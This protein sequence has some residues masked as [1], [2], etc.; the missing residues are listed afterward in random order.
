MPH[1]FL[2][3]LSFLQTDQLWPLIIL[4]GFL[5]F[6]SLVPLPPNDFWWHLKI[7][8]LIYNGKSIPTTNLFAWTLSPDA[9]FTYGAWLGELLM[10]LFYKIGRLELVTFMRTL[11]A[12]ITFWLVAY[13]SWR[14]SGSW[15]LSA[16]A[17]ALAC[18]MTINNLPTRPQIWSWVPF[19]IYLILLGKYVDRQIHPRWLLALPALMIFWVNAH[20]AFILGGVLIGI[21][22][23]GEVLRKLIFPKDS[24]NWKEIAY[25]GGSGV[26]TGLTMFINPRHIGIIRYVINLMTDQP[27]QKLI[28]EWQSP[29]PVGIANTIF[30]LSI[31]ILIVGLIFTKNRLTITEALLILCFLWLAWSGQRYVVWYGLVCTPIITKVIRGLPLSL[32]QLTPQKNFLNLIITIILFIPVL[33]VQPWFVERFPLPERYWKLVIRHS[34][35]GPLVGVET[36]VEA[37]EYL[38]EHPG[39]KLFNEMGYGSYLIWAL[40]D[41]SVFIDP[42]VE[43]YPFDQWEDY[44]HITNGLRYNE[45]LDKYGADRLL[46]DT[47]LQPELAQVLENDPA[48]TEEYQ[49]SRSQIWSKT[50]P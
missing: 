37:V 47:Q 31:L 13:E 38:R 23:V 7:G 28:V 35:V 12:G 11:L 42:R 41:Q 25:L 32:P 43:L 14:K 2:K 48:W 27:S 44:V 46:I 20:G 45:L 4:A 6:V 18:G 1:N 24:L 16:L 15:R 40:P 19:M 26:L 5:F 50:S 9:P 34:P 22:F 29:S 39:G 21:F 30:Y 36:P 17:V 49:G 10:Y 33:F 3:R 8:E